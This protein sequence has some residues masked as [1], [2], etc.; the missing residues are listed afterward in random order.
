MSNLIIFDPRCIAFQQSWTE[1]Y[2]KMQSEINQTLLKGELDY[3]KGWGEKL[4][5]TN[6]MCRL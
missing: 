4:A 1:R 3:F 2:V 5:E 6:K